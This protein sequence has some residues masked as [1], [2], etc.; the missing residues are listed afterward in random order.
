M[1]EAPVFRQS[2]LYKA[3]ARLRQVGRFALLMWLP[4]AALLFWF[5]RDSRGVYPPQWWG[6][7]FL[8]HWRGRSLGRCSGR[9]FAEV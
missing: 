4:I 6:Y 9:G 5:P 2:I 1:S 7:V 8:F 3:S